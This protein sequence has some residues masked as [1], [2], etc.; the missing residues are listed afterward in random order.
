MK[1]V[2]L[3]GQDGMLGGELFSRLSSYTDLYEVE[4]TTLQTLDITDLDAVRA[5]VQEVQPY[6]II[7][8]AAYTNVDGCETNYD[9]AEAVNGIAVGNL[10]TTAKEVGATLIQISTDYV[11]D[12]K[13][14]VEKA[15]TEDMAPNPVSA[16]GRTKLMGEENAKRAEKYYIL[17]TAWLYGQGKNFVRT[18][19]NAAKTRDEVTVVCDQHGS[20]TS[21]RT[22]ASMR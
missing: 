11:F 20:P 18:M 13:L 14:D 19:L 7:N 21:T 2:L 3:V 17:R 16:Y 15:Y 22:S 10:A 5:K 6:F 9:L 1:K 8:C 12:G 4:S